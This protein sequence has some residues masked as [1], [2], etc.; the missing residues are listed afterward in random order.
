MVD[1]LATLA[2]RVDRLVDG[3]RERMP[4]D[5][6]PILHAGHDVERSVDCQWA[7]G[8]LQFVG[9]HEGATAE[10]AHV[11]GERAGTLREHHYRHALFQ[12]LTRLVVG[13]LYLSGI[14]KAAQ[15]LC[16]FLPNNYQILLQESALHICPL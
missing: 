6:M 8:Q 10:E 12:G 11:A 13:L 14:R 5:P 4:I 15:R 3:E 16:S 7:D 9:K 2:Y 1:V